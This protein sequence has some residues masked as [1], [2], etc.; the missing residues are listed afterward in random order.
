MAAFGVIAD[1]IGCPSGMPLAMRREASPES[2]WAT[3]EQQPS[4]R[5]ASRPHGPQRLR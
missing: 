3:G 1:E 2:E 4:A 5:Q